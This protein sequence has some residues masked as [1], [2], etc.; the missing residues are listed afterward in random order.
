MD[1]RR[2]KRRANTAEEAEEYGRNVVERSQDVRITIHNPAPACLQ[3][4]TSSVLRISSS[5]D[6]HK[7]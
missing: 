7:T 5:R 1:G 2:E 3:A 4:E 6:D